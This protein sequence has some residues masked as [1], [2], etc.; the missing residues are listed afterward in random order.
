MHARSQAWQMTACSIRPNSCEDPWQGCPLKGTSDH[1]NSAR[2]R[3]PTWALPMRARAAWIMS[4]SMPRREAMLRALD[5][6]G[7]PH[8]RRYVGASLA[9]SNSTL[10]FSKRSSWYFRE[11]SELHL[12]QTQRPPPKRMAVTCQMHRSCSSL[13]STACWRSHS[14]GPGSPASGRDILTIMWACKSYCGRCPR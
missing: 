3:L 12:D 10:A 5:L 9:S 2:A 11:V 1:S 7:M 8:M 14:S 13:S 6:P 4:A